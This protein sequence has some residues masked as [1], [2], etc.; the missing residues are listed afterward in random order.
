VSL[1]QDAA[2]ATWTFATEAYVLDT[3]GLS[4]WSRR[5]YLWGDD[6]RP[7]RLPFR[8]RVRE[9][10]LATRRLD[11]FGMDDARMEAF[12]TTLER[13][14]PALL[15]GY[16]GA[17]DLF[18]AFLERRGRHGI[19]PRV[20]RSSAEALSP[21]A[22][23]RVERAFGCPVRDFYGS[24]ESSGL[25]AEC[26]AGGFHVLAAGRVVEVV[27]DEGRACPP[28]VPG[29]VLVTDLRNRAF[30]L[31]RYEN[32]DVASF[33]DDEGPPCPCGCPWPRLER[34]HG[35][36]SDFLTTPEGRRIHGEWFTH[37][38]YGSRGVER[39]QVRQGAPDAVELAT[40]GP[41][42]EADLAPVLARMREALGPAVS[43][44]WRRVERIADTP[45]GKRRFTVSA[46]PYLPEA[47]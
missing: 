30:A 40:V 42:D 11:A 29:R 19:A 28:G 22:R 7:D 38:L 44:T 6:R 24:R 43:V 17:L 33:A 21:A 46:V 47:S 18:A 1:Y 32:G 14:R 15:Q 3:W 27:D 31:V 8:E 39:F 45:S 36:T 13:F 25:A 23:A 37:L 9:R 2:H 35:R 41:A 16:A 12:T 34:V 5:A 4:P 10:L 26:A 20:V